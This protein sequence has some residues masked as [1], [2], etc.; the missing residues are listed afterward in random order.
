MVLS[1]AIVVPKLLLNLL[2]TELNPAILEPLHHLFLPVCWYYLLCFYILLNQRYVAE[3]LL[4][5]T[6]A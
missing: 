3:A 6:V 1:N 5:N 2:I 4:P